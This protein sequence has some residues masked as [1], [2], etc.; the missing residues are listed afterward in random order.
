MRDGTHHYGRVISIAITLVVTGVVVW[1]VATG[2]WSDMGKIKMDTATI[3][4]LSTIVSTSPVPV[5]PTP[6]ESFVVTETK[7]PAVL[8]TGSSTSKSKI[9]KITQES[10]VNF[11]SFSYDAMVGKLITV[12]GTC[13]DKYYAMLVFES[14]DD[15]R[16]NPGAA[17]SNRAFECKASGTFSVETNMKEFNLPSGNYY[18][19]VADQGSTGSWYN[20]R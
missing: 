14:R 7:A 13:H 11:K 15:Y 19:F 18:L 3:A 8:V 4:P 5:V 9:D 16:K 10:P 17:K 1:F 2:R 12:S 20:P 6:S